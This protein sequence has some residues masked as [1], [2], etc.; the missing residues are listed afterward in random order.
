MLRAWRLVPVS[1]A[2]VC[3]GQFQEPGRTWH[4]TPHARG[5]SLNAHTRG[6]RENPASPFGFGRRQ[7]RKYR[8]RK[9]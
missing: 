3:C 6:S 1:V 4:P 7:E 8:A 5:G 9:L 2:P